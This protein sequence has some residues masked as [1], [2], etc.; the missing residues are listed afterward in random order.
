[1]SDIAIYSKL[2]AKP[3]SGAGSV[4]LIIGPN[5]SIVIEPIRSSHF[6][7]AYDFYK[8]ELANDFPIVNGKLSTDLYIKSLI[9]S[10][11]RLKDKNNDLELRNIDFF[12]FHC[13]FTKQVRKAFLGLFFNEFRSNPGFLKGLG[14]SEAFLEELRRKIEN[15]DSFYDQKVQGLI[16]KTFA[17]II[18][19]KLEP[20]LVLP[21][22]I[23]NTYTASLYLSL[24]SL[25]YNFADRPQQIM[26]KRLML[27]SYGSGL[28]SSLLT[29]KFSDNIDKLR[30]LIN[31]RRISQDL[32]TSSLYTA[33]EFHQ[34]ENRNE[35][36]FNKTN[37]STNLESKL[38]SIH[39]LRDVWPETYYLKSVDKLHIRD[40]VFVNK[41]SQ[42]VA[43]NQIKTNILS[44]QQISNQRNL[45]FRELPIKNR[46]IKL[47]NKFKIENLV[48]DLKSGGL[49]ES[50]A[51]NM[52]EN[53]IGI[54]SLLIHDPR[55]GYQ[56]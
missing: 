54:M 37:L 49:S 17:K 27:Y 45:K 32:N 9:V 30:R 41:S 48:Q 52:T 38:N 22:V 21:S 51:N 24:I 29:L 36:N 11:K 43:F 19:E 2:S 35:R 7:N 5:P 1:M 6:M 50:S 34:I 40:Y 3:T 39:N 4:A 25:I 12:C 14:I 15:G 23:G 42:L 53:C 31:P 28:A 44:A 55:F 10:W 18:K 56:R 20:G 47:A 26:N 13:P 46:Q 16:K 8:P 33:K